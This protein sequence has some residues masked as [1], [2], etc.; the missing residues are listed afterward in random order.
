[1]QED[2][3]DNE[4]EEMDDMGEDD[5][6]EVYTLTDE[7]GNESDF[8]LLGRHDEDG[9]SYVALAPMDPEEGDEEQEG[10]FIVLKVVEED[11]EEIFET[12]E[13]DSEFDRIA[14]IFEDELMQELDYDSDETDEMEEM[15]ETE[16]AEENGGSDE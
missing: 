16:E 15:D 13:D 10:S 6:M 12:I 5:E 8:E 1:M 4:I 2:N 7:D 9:Q 11:G 14:D 3:F